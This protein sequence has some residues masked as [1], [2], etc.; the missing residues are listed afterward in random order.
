MNDTPQYTPA[1]PNLA[2]FGFLCF[3]V[4]ILSLPMWTGHYL[5]GPFSD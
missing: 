3:W 2:A 5:A 1:R 4:A